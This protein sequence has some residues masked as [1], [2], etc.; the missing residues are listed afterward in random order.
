MEKFENSIFN[1]QWDKALE[2]ISKDENLIFELNPYDISWKIFY[3][4]LVE[5]GKEKHI[6]PFG[7]KTD[8]NKL[9]EICKVNG[10]T[11][12]NLPQATAFKDKNQINFLLENGHKIN[13]EDFGERTA[14][15]VASALNDK[16]LVSFLI[17]KNANVSHFDQDN[18]EAIDFTTSNEI[19][20][21]LKAN[22]GKTE[23]ERDKEYDDYCNARESLNESREI[24]LSFMKS[25]ENGNFE[26]LE[27]ALNQSKIKTLTLNFAY[28]I[29]GWTALHYA[30]KNN[31]K[32]SVKFLIEN[33]IDIE[34]RNLDNLT[35]KELAEQLERTNLFTE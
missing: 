33:G 23:Q 34:K 7:K 20:E 30:V 28:P 10:I 14:L 27:K 4:S 22:G 24:N 3:Y 25:A 9:V 6:P 8:L 11:G 19:I 32:K 21:I 1:E 29:N 16:E 26:K 13:E 15:I 17:K 35:A 2:F 12:K 5:N 31:D 18:L